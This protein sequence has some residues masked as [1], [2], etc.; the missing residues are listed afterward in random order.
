M[1]HIFCAAFWI[2]GLTFD[3]KLCYYFYEVMTMYKILIVDDET[4]IRSLIRKYA[5][6]EGHS[7]AEAV[8]GMDAISKFKTEPWKTG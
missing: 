2:Y 4:M 5:E 8:D 7:V 6:F 3:F 1:Q